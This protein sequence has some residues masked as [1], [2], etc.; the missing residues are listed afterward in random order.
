[1]G[2]EE[3]VPLPST[4][5]APSRVAT[6]RAAVSSSKRNT[7]SDVPQ[8]LEVIRRGEHRR[9]SSNGGNGYSNSSINSNNFGD[10]HSFVSAITMDKHLFQSVI[11]GDDGL[12]DY[13]NIIDDDLPPPTSYNR[14]PGPE[15]V[16]GKSN[17]K[18]NHINNSNT[19]N[20]YERRHSIGG[21][22][23]SYRRRRHTSNS[24][25]NGL[26]SRTRHLYA[27]PAI[28]RSLSPPDEYRNE[29]PTDAYHYRD[30]EIPNHRRVNSESDF[31]SAENFSKRLKNHSTHTQ[32]VRTS[33]IMRNHI[34]R[35]RHESHHD[36]SEKNV[37]SDWV[38][39]APQSPIT[40][41]LVDNNEDE[42]MPSFVMD[43][44][45]DYAY[46]Q[47]RLRQQEQQQYQESEPNFPRSRIRAFEHRSTTTPQA[48][49]SPA[50]STTSGPQAENTNDSSH[51]KN[52]HDM[53]KMITEEQDIDD[54]P[55]IL[56]CLNKEECNP[57]IREQ[58]LHKLVEIMQNTNENSSTGD[59][60]RYIREFIFENNVIE[61]VT[62]SMWADMAIVEVQEAAM[63]VLLFIAASMEVPY[64]GVD[65]DGE[66]RNRNDNSCV[67][68]KNE[69]VCD[70]ILFAMQNHPS[71]HEIQLKGSLLFASLSASS[72]D[73]KNVGAN[74]DGSLSGAVTMVLNAMANH[75]DSRSIRKA[76]LQALHHQ[77][78]LSAYA[79]DNK[80]TFVESKLGNG[81]P[82]ID[83]V[84]YAMEELQKDVVA[85]EWACQL[86]WCLTTN[87]DLLKHLEHASLHEGTMTICQHYMTNPAGTSLVEA[88]IGT[89]AN[90]AYLTKKR[91]EM[92][93]TGA[94]ELVL[95]GLRYHGDSFGI[96]YEA[97]FALENFALPPYLPDVSSLLLKSEAVPLLTKGLNKFL[98]CPE[99]AIQG[100][101]A[102]TGIAT[103]S[104]EAKRRI[105]SPEIISIVHKSSRKHMS[106]DVIEICCLFVAT[107]AMGTTASLSEAMIEHRVLD[108]LLFAMERFPDE[109]LQDAAC[110]ALRNISCH[111]AK[112]E[113]LCRDGKTTKLI[114]G[115]MDMHRNSVSIQTNGCGIFWN[116]LS[117]AN[118]KDYDFNPKIVNSITKAMQSHIESGDLLELACGALWAI[119]NRF[120]DQK[121]YVG[122]ESI[123]VVTCAMVMHPGTTST[124]EKACGFLSNLSSV[125]SLAKSIAKAQGVSIVS[126]AMCN[127]ASSISLLESG[128]L[129]LKNIILVCPTYAQDGAVAIS[130]LVMAMNE[131]IGS[132][133]FVKEACDL[134]WVLASENESIRA[135][136]LALDGLSTLMKCLE[137]NRTHPEVETSAL[138]AFNQLAKS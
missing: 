115:A 138:G 62:K 37:S 93:N 128:C 23:D 41:A 19:F 84:I 15:R 89:I 46:N 78:L 21:D 50:S 4:M 40:S 73:N 98:D 63:N 95:D 96:S 113:K 116:L 8:T 32:P 11:G 48:T 104:D 67:L 60:E 83:L 121:V 13:S 74:A 123:D 25:Q 110:L 7:Q 47:N 102:L 135:K 133:S 17:Q 65:C 3:T 72:S 57:D 103:Q 66:P 76:G 6:G 100:F 90:L 10:D 71:I 87:E 82:A 64:S 58:A 80:R 22:I 99:Y 91:N 132:T 107:L 16:A 94:V 2:I 24:N 33:S 30:R 51:L 77:C 124:L 125:E 55:G 114:V 18:R 97:A 131:N 28:T 45:D 120:D 29:P 134:L 38:D 75:G 69:W 56:Q 35:N 79:G 26:S 81:M 86:C 52:S 137:Q 27:P 130:T 59:R 111:I 42:D 101:R 31:G 85:M 54:M 9:S 106:T 112:S 119:V 20:S 34:Q 53:S 136:I 108:L 88:S 1:M 126:E 117:K 68:S 118:E 5:L 44:N 14:H 109:K 43:D 105:C 61:A 12:F 49:V 129:T 39:L 127:N 122:N 92:I 70:S 36:I